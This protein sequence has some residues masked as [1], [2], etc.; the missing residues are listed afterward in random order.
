MKRVLLIDDEP[1]FTAAAMINLES[2][3]MYEVEVVNDPRVALVKALEFQPDIIL[4]DV[5]MPAIDGGDVL[6][7]LRSHQQLQDV[8]VVLVTGIVKMDDTAGGLGVAE[9]EGQIML[10]KP[11]SLDMVIKVIDKV[12]ND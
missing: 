9:E 8:P 12:L 10:A 5:I 4:L 3:G 1:D 7:L 6:T 11:V 2:T